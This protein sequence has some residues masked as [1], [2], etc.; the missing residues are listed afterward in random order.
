VYGRFHHVLKRRDSADG[1]ATGYGLDYRGG[2]GLSRIAVE[3]YKGRA[4]LLQCNPVPGGITG[5]VCSWGDINTGTWP[6]R[7]EESQM[8]H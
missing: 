5:P 8:R 1:M 4:V 3:P 2:R 6:S 7:L